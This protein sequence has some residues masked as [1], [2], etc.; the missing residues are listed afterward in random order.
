MSP[1]GRDQKWEWRKRKAKVKMKFM[2]TWGVQVPQPTPLCPLVYSL[3]FCGLHLWASGLV[4]LLAV[5]TRVS[6]LALSTLPAVRRGR[7]AA[8]M[9]DLGDRTGRCN[10]TSLSPKREAVSFSCQYLLSL[11]GWQGAKILSNATHSMSS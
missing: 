4:E 8:E 11:A 5:P 2:S 7:G 9:P 10:P 6:S 1:R 3:P